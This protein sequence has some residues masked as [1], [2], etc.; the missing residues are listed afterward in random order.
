VVVTGTLTLL[1]TDAATATEAARAV[2]QL[3]ARLAGAH[4][5]RR[6]AW[7]CDTCPDGDTDWP[8]SPAL[9]RLS[10]H[11]AGDP[12]GLAA[13]LGALD[14]AAYADQPAALRRE[15]RPDWPVL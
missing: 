5:P 2:E 1:A 15:L 11:Y 3:P 4:T 13:Y 7:T 10:E 8:C 12:A 14:A 9:V 6:P